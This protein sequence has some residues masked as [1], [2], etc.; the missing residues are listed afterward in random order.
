[1]DKPRESSASPLMVAKAVF[2]SFL[3]IRRSGDYQRDAVRI[4]PVQVVIGG[5]VGALLFVLALLGVVWL[6][7][8]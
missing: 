1:M 5:L 3:G 2:W 8:H 6:V 7:T 4:T